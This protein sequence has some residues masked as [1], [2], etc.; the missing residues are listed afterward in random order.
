[1]FELLA[2]EGAFVL[3][4]DDRVEPARRVRHRRERP[5]RLRP[6]RSGHRAGDT[7]FEELDHD[8]TMTGDQVLGI[9]AL[10]PARRRPVLEV[11]RGHTAVEREPQPVNRPGETPRPDL[12]LLGG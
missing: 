2:V 4:H 12:L 11:D 3:A 7:L 9:V 10:P 8:P 5:C 1:M 6:V